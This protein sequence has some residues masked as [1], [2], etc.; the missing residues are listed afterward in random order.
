MIRAVK[1]RLKNNSNYAVLI[2]KIKIK[3][4]YFAKYCVSVYGA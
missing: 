2:K 3:F 4:L 1:Y